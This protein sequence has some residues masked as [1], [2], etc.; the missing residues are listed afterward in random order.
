MIPLSVPNLNGKEWEYIKEC[1]DT[2]WIS[3]VG[4]YVTRFEKAIS[5]YTGAKYSIA[6]CNGT[7]ALHIAL[8]LHKISANDLVIL[9]NI[10][11]VASINSIKYTGADVALIDVDPHTW[12]INLDLLEQF[13]TNECVN[14]NDN[15]IH[16]KS[17]KIVKAIMP[18]HVLGNMCDMNKLLAIA[19][20]FNL[21]VIEDATEAMGSYYNN[22]HAG[23]LGD[24]GCF[25][26]NGNKIMTTGGGGM[27]VTDNEELA[28]KAKHL[29]TQAKCDNQEYIHD[30]IGYNYRLVNIL[31]AMG[32][33]QLEQLNVFIEKKLF[34]KNYYTEKLKR[35]D[36]QYQTVLPNVK[37]NNWLYTIRVPDKNK[38]IQ[39]LKKKN[40]E[41]RSLWM[42]MNM[43]PMYNEAIYVTSENVSLSLY[44]SAISLPCSTGITA[45]EIDNVCSSIIEFY[46]SQS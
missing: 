16:A 7:S 34:I 27:I 2:N 31:A 5:E 23:T 30:E 12:Q 39:H 28:K 37:C 36:F 44:N 17:R 11:F 38:L 41:S 32:V 46:D 13:L 40:I 25:S 35:L 20:Q 26:F 21:I 9:P 10:T 4:Q 29:T 15:T 14:Q 19:K 1:I 45:T 22:Q 24:I 43:L 42:P 18:V 6:C 3:S 8:L 33:A